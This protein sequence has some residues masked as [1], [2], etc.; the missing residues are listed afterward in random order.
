MRLLKKEK[1]YQDIVY[2][3]LSENLEVSNRIPTE[4]ELCEKFGVSR[5]TLRIA[6]D[7]LVEEGIL[8]RDGRNGTRVKALPLKENFGDLARQ[9]I[10]FVYFSS[11]ADGKTLEQT[12]TAPEQLY[13]GIEKYIDEKKDIII[14]QT[15]K[16]FIKTNTSILKNIDGVIIGGDVDEESVKKIIS[17]KIPSMMING[18]KPLLSMNTIFCDQ[19]EAGYVACKKVYEKNKAQ[20]ILFLGLLYEN[21]KRLQSGYREQLQG[22]EEFIYENNDMRLF[23]YDLTVSECSGGQDLNNPIEQLNAFINKNHISG[24]VVCSN[25]LEEQVSLYKEKYKTSGSGDISVCVITTEALKNRAIPLDIV[26]LNFQ[27]VGYLAAGYLYKTIND[28]YGQ[29]LRITVPIDL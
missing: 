22:V 18:H 17:S 20:N 9:Q 27:K 3:I 28:P 7:K 4:R 24:I 14:V 13:R 16:N 8:M 21:D 29:K 5:I 26:S 23:R 1:I 12:G 25:I 15:G 19:Y 11:Q 10:L 2:Y 6:V